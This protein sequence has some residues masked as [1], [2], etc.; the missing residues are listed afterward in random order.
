VIQLSID[1]FIK[2]YKFASIG[3]LVGGLIH[4]LN[5]PM[6][7]LGLDIEMAH[8]SLKDES[9]W[10][11]NIAQNIIVRLQ[12]MEEEH[13][14][15]NSLIK[16]TSSRSG[17]NAELVSTLSD[18]NEFLKQELL[19]LNTNL[20]F[21]H[22]V[23]TEIINITDPPLLTSSLPSNSIMALGWFLQT[24]I[25]EIE[26][27]K[28]KGLIIKI[29]SDNLNLK[30]TFSTQEGKLSEGFMEQFKNA[31]SI[32][33]KSKSDNMDLGIFLVLMLFKSN[34]TT[35]EYDTESS[36]SSIII[37]FPQL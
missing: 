22:N 1:D 2:L 33:E 23:Q 28:I 8:F 13:E 31:T 37:N 17:E 26:R 20:Y 7:N 32:S 27:Q 6:Q 3:K 12:R 14:R 4:N 19:F 11:N 34:G 25:E 18:I 29:F 35:I 9:K 15:I 21:K 30:I 24:F 5:G 36:S 10:N 16:T